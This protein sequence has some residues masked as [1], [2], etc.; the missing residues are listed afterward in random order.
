MNK[1][2]QSKNQFFSDVKNELKSMNKSKDFC[3]LVSNCKNDWS[4]RTELANQIIPLLSNK[5]HIWGTGYE[6]C[7]NAE[8]RSNAIN[9]GSFPGH[10]YELYKPQQEK[11]K[12]CKFYFA[13][14]NAICSDF[15]TEKFSNA[16]EVGAI[17]IVNGWRKSYEEQ[18]P[19]SF[20][21]VSDFETTTDLANYLK[22]L[23]TNEDALMSYHKWRLDYEIE[24]IYLQPACELCRELKQYKN[25][26]KQSIIHDVDNLQFALQDCKKV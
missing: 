24:K 20:I 10:Y 26:P 19:G 13:F 5:L 11:M 14:D 17:P 4:K 6:K 25:H 23:L 7:L 8:S 1:K 9:H 16:L 18:V 21:H 15:V 3:W 2:T 22:Y 12:D